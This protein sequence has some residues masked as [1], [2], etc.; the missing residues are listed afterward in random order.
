MLDHQL[1]RSLG[2]QDPAVEV[3]EAA[4]ALR[5]HRQVD[6]RFSTACLD[7]PGQARI[8]DLRILEFSNIRNADPPAAAVGAV[9]AQRPVG[10]AQGWDLG[11]TADLLPLVLQGDQRPPDRDA[12][13]EAA[14][15]VDG[16]DDP[17]KTG[18]ARLIAR[19]LTQECVFWKSTEQPLA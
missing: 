5:L 19:L 1:A 11:H 15:A 7:E 8:E 4:L 17:A 18:G 6:E 10:E 3:A 12:T 9:A 2:D 16:V 14:R 13:H